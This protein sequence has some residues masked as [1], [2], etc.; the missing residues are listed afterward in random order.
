MGIETDIILNRLTE[1]AAAI[2][3][4]SEKVDN[5]K[6]DHNALSKRVDLIEFQCT[7]CKKDRKEEA[8]NKGGT[9]KKVGDWM[10]LMLKL[11]A[12]LAIISG[13]MYGIFKLKELIK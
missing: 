13:V 2:E 9:V 3:K 12:M 4:L 11:C 7:E 8:K 1:I 6:D 5:M 10:G